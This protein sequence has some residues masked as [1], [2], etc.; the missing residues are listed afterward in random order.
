[1]SIAP[2]EQ[3]VRTLVVP[4][5]DLALINEIDAA[6]ACQYDTCFQQVV[7]PCPNEAT[8]IAMFKRQCEHGGWLEAG[9]PFL[10][11]AHKEVFVTGG[12][13]LCGGCHCPLAVVGGWHHIIVSF[14]EIK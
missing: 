14:Q 9:D 7:A 4:D 5:I 1:M 11:T 12:N 6:Q 10:C 8:W 3:D 13:L 2:P